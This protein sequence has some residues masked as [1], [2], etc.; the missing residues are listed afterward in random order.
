MI[1]YIIKRLLMLIPVVLGV[2]IIAFM[3]Q[4]IAPGDPA[5]QILGASATDEEKFSL[6]EELGLED[7][8][9]VQFGRYVWN[10]VTKGELGISYYT[11]QSVAKE[12]M[13]RFPVTVTLAV[14]SVV[15]GALFGV[16]LGI[17]A[18]VKQ[19]T[20]IDS[21]IL[22]FSVFLASIPGFWLALML[23]SKFSVDLGWLPVAGITQPT[24]WVL[25]I[26][27]VCIMSMAG[28]VRNTRSSM[29][30]TIRQ[31][32]IRTARAKGQKERVIIF[33]H[34][35]S[36][37]LIPIVAAVGNRMGHMLGGALVI[38]S[39]FGLPGIGRY[40]ADAT[41]QR[42]YP[43]VVGSVVVLSIVY[44]LV[45]L[46]LDLV[47]FFINPRMRT[48]YFSSKKKKAKTDKE[49]AANG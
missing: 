23:I 26:V 35:L 39:V 5:D 44:T 42:D 3:F 37:S 48:S 41:L 36:N 21:A 40:A 15:L 12:I 30:E 18:A 46:I 13:S 6:R 47:Y 27:V 29:L 7:P 43:A 1:R 17:L 8:V 28:L 22:A 33:K 32:Y 16:P 14:C 11:K 24:G 20:W 10:F 45:N 25:P 9:I 19:Y 31:D 38:E 4:V 34:V 49:V 2:M